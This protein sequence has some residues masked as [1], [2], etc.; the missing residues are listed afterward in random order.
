VPPRCLLPLLVAL[1]AFVSNTAA[2]L[3]P[4]RPLSQYGHSTWKLRA[5]AI[6]GQPIDMTQT[7]DGYLWLGTSAGLLRFDGVRFTPWSA[8][9]ER[10]LSAGLII[11]LEPDPAGGLWVGTDDGLDHVLGK[12]HVA[13]WNQGRASVAAILPVA[14][15]GAWIM[16]FPNVSDPKLLCRIG[17]GPAPVCFGQEAGLRGYPGGPQ[18]IARDP[19]GNLWLATDTGIIRWKDRTAR[20]FPIHGLESRAG[21]EGVY[22]LLAEP[23]GSLLVGIE[24]SGTGLGLERF[25]DG[26][27]TPVTGRHFDGSKLRVTALLRDKDG[28]LWIG[29]FDDGL[30]RL[31]GAAADHFTTADGLSDSDIFSLFQDR[32][33]TIWASTSG[34][35]D[36]FWD[37]PV[38]T[39]TKDIHSSKV[40]GV[41]VSRDGRLW[42]AGFGGLDTLEPGAAAFTTPAGDVSGRQ[43][44]TTFEDSAGRMWVG[45]DNALNILENGRLVP[46][47][48]PDKEPVGMVISMAEDRDGTLWAISLGPPRALLRIDPDKRVAF[49]GPQIPAVSRIAA[50]PEGG[51]WL[52][53]L[54]GG[55][56]LF[57]QG[58]VETLH[59]GVR[60]GTAR[61]RQ[62]SVES[63]GGLYA[64]TP[65]GLIAWRAGKSALMTKKNGL[66]C[67]DLL[68]TLFDASG[69][70]WLYMMC[71]LVEIER[72]DLEKWW[73]DT[74]VRV[75]V[76]VFDAL[77]GFLPG[78][79]AAFGGAGRT[80][81]GRLWFANST[82]LQMVDPAHLAHNALRP[83][84]H[85]QSVVA[86]QRRY[87][88]AQGLSL[89]PLTHDLEID[90]AALSFVIPGKVKFR[91]TLE[92][93]DPHWNDAGT[94]RQAFY[95]SLPPGAYRFRVIASNNDGVWNETGATLAFKLR[96]AYYQTNGFQLS[97]VT[98]AAILLWL[99]FRVRIRQVA[100]RAQLLLAERHAERERI[101]RDLHDTLLQGIQGLLF[102][103]QLWEE[104]ARIPAE[105]RAEISAVVRQA[106]AIV[107][108]GR[109]KLISL[110]HKTLEPDE[111]A[112]ALQAIGDAESLARPGHFE[113]NVSGRPRELLPATYE[114]LLAIGAEG[115]RNA[116]THSGG[117][118]I[119][120]TIDYRR[121]S[122][123]IMIADDGRGFLESNLGAGLRGHYG[124]RG[125]RERAAQLGALLTVET[126]P[127]A[128]T[129]IFMRVR[130][131]VAFADRA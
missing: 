42:V 119:A 131:R 107:I 106:R 123:D 130:A 100:G 35:V 17:G 114:Q 96:P 59:P 93:F 73:R 77:D 85:I 43:V 8:V 129:K 68:A 97:C 81:D 23:D 46:V 60:T 98:L 78:L 54:D 44:T 36:S 51:L 83:P 92:G 72:G 15:G 14:D 10:P 109:D 4:A 69:N 90:Y 101:A 38:L 50:N 110:R 75:N 45:T 65:F 26:K 91:Y 124:L 67:D 47:T 74:T 71:G 3:N 95:T 122:L 37:T 112:G 16:Q 1:G 18:S 19:A 48:R 34:G 20:T 32:E 115:I 104:D 87:P 102:R 108:E 127:A 7:D 24:Q 13:S 9:S 116:F 105:R 53:L 62:F 99:L 6:P 28:A 128:G 12:T 63:D 25:A 29:T 64:S 40:D 89:P 82:V 21:D 76:S 41:Y 88:V 57:R 49:T 118:H 113:L 120:V 80:A 103:L 58:T 55:V 61:V 33:G 79:D 94:R 11:A 86:D 84:V 66:P 30:Y 22:A 39:F 5:G 121:R 70:L 2:A 126:A 52:G 125:M 111:L 56:A 27:F 117:A 31:F